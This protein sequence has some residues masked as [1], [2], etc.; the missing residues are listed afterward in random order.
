MLDPGRV[1]LSLNRR[2][3]WSAP[4]RSRPW[5]WAWA[6]AAPLTPRLRLAS[7][8]QPPGRR[9]RV[10]C[11]RHPLPDRGVDDEES[12]AA[13]AFIGGSFIATWASIHNDSHYLSQSLLGWSIGAVA[14]CNVNQTEVGRSQV[15]LCRSRCRRAWG[16][17]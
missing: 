13:W 9:H 12:A 7:A 16:V 4:P 3:C 5:I 10:V 11:R 15:E 14:T 2:A 8:A 6:R 1:G 17:A